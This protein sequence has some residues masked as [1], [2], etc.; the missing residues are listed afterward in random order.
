MSTEYQP[1]GAQTDA[2]GRP[3]AFWYTSL[4]YI[5]GGAALIFF[6]LSTGR[7]RYPMK[8]SEAISSHETGIALLLLALSMALIGVFALKAKL[9]A[10]DRN[11][12]AYLLIV[13]SPF[14]M[15][16]MYL[17]QFFTPENYILKPQTSKP[18][19]M[20]LPLPFSFFLIIYAWLMWAG[21][22]AFWRKRQMSLSRFPQELLRAF[23]RK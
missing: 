16:Q 7:R 14:L 18:A 13:T 4:A 8:L 17:S 11:H 6:L 19:I 22:N 1:E 9:P 21:F 10:L 5:C 3:F 12:L 23:L 15:N 20:R 2:G